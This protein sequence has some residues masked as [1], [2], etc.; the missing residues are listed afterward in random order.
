VW[1]NKFTIKFYYE[2]AFSFNNVS[3]QIYNTNQLIRLECA[4]SSRSGQSMHKCWVSLH[5]TH[6]L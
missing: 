6:P 1:Q 5:M 2:V 3:E 4:N